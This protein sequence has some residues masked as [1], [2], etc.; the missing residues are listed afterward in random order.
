MHPSTASKILVV[1]SA[2]DILAAATQSK[3]SSA[4]ADVAKPVP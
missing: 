3:R 2:A 4:R 1:E